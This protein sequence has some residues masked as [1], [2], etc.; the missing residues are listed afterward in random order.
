MYTAWTHDL[1]QLLSVYPSRYTY[2]MRQNPTSATELGLAIAGQSSSGSALVMVK[3][4]GRAH[5]HIAWTKREYGQLLA[6]DE[7]A[8]GRSI[9]EACGAD[10]ETEGLVT[11]GP[12]GDAAEPEWQW[13]PWLGKAIGHKIWAHGVLFH[14]TG[15]RQSSPFRTRWM[16]F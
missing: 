8:P 12:P 7:E 5:T 13:I 14:T 3:M 4:D 9:L 6:E 16:Q 15:I 11:W 2:R 1:V 10:R